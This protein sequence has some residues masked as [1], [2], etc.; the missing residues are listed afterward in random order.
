MSSWL[1]AVI[2][3][4]HRVSSLLLEGEALRQSLSLEMGGLVQTDTLAQAP[5]VSLCDPQADQTCASAGHIAG[6]KELCKDKLSVC[7]AVL[8]VAR[9]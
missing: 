2:S 3:V 7:A 4:Y 5:Q 1:A 6:G 9:N 8:R